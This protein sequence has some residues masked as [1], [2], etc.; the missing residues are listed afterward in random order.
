[1]NLNNFLFSMASTPEMSSDDTLL[2]VTTFCFDISFLEIFLPL[3]CSSSLYLASSSESRDSQKIIDIIAKEDITVMQATPVTWSLLIKSGWKGSQSLKALCGGEKLDY[4]LAQNILSRVDSLWNMYGPT[5]TTIWSSVD[6]VLAGKQIS[7]GKPIYNTNFYILD[8]KLEPVGEGEVGELYISGDGV[9]KGYLNAPQ[10]TSRCFI[11]SS[12]NGKDQIIYKTGDLASLASGSVFCHGRCDNQIKIRGY[13]IEVD[14]IKTYVKQFLKDEVEGVEILLVGD[15]YM[16]KLVLYLESAQSNDNHG[17]LK[18]YLQKNLPSYMIPTEIFNVEKFPKTLN[19]KIDLKELQKFKRSSNVF[20]KKD[21]EDFSISSKVSQIWSS[22]LEID[23]RST[24]EDFFSQG[25][26]S[27]KALE[28]VESINSV[29]NINLDLHILF[30]FNTLTKLSELISDMIIEKKILNKEYEHIVT[31]N[32]NI[33]NSV[34]IFFIHGVGGSVLNYKHFQY[35]FPNKNVFAVKANGLTDKI[36]FNLS[37]PEM[38]KIYSHEISEISR[39]SEVHLVGGSMGGVIAYELADCLYTH[40]HNLNK[41]VLLDSYSPGKSSLL[42]RSKI[43]CKFIKTYLRS[44]F[45]NDETN[46]TKS[47]L[48]ELRNLYALARYYPQKKSTVPIHLIKAK[49]NGNPIS[50]KEWI[51]HT[52]GEFI[53]KHIDAYHEDIIESEEL[54]PMLS[55]ILDD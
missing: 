24:E 9:S 28:F 17:E 7:I 54:I 53:L 45:E 42:Y 22:V 40:S 34:N 51:G 16:K 48:V 14:E 26:N 8:E 10:K 41:V 32:Y 49:L 30:E 21:I 44:E 1:S 3:Y 36:Q 25:G 6:R 38:A 46:T 20:D 37:L 52:S 55:T 27:I 23:T 43:I 50:E 12:I 11:S 35:A 39:G 29:F 18:R 5:E 47:R 31:L 13:R 33:N 15:D 4:S 2:A 19:N